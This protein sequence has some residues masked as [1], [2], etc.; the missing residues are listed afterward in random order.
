[1]IGATG[2]DPMDVIPLAIIGFVAIAGPSI[3][4][5]GDLLAEQPGTSAVLAARN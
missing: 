3:L 4:A 5:P 2:G 1:M